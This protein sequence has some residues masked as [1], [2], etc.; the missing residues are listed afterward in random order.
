MVIGSVAVALVFDTESATVT[1]TEKEPP[2]VGVPEITPAVERFK[3]AGRDDPLAAAHVQ[4]SLA[5][6][7]EPPVAASVVLG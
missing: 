2:A 5:L 7:P 1:T 4:E 3:P 6:E